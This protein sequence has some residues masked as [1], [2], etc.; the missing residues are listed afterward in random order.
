MIDVPRNSN[1]SVRSHLWITAALK[2]L[3]FSCET[4]HGESKL[5]G[6]RGGI[7]SF[8]SRSVCEEN[9]S[10]V[11]AKSYMIFFVSKWL[12]MMLVIAQNQ[13]SIENFI[14][15]HLRRLRSTVQCFKFLLVQEMSIYSIETRCTVISIA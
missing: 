11:V 6:L 7:M 10:F 13:C 3:T 8:A 2:P 5:N 15:F 14:I 1:T 9:Q 12:L 4:T